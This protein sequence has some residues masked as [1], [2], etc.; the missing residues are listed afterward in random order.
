MKASP[1][2]LVI[3]CMPLLAAIAFCCGCRSLEQQVLFHPAPLAEGTRAAMFAAEDVGFESGDGTR[4]HGWYFR[5]PEPRAV[6]L[7]CHGNGGNLTNWAK[8]VRQLREELG[9][10]VLIFDYRGYG[11][12]EGKPSIAGI[13]D[14]ARAARA[15]LAAREGIGE[16][17]IVLM[18]HSLGGAVAVDLAA[19]DGAKALVVRGSFTSLPDIAGDH[20][21][22]LPASW[23]LSDELDSRAKLAGYSGPTLIAHG[24][25]DSLIPFH[26]GEEL[27]Q[28]AAGPKKF[29]P[30]AGAGHNDPPDDEL[31]RELAI[32]FAYLDQQRRLVS[33]PP[34]PLAPVR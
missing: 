13:L 11:R 2:M 14:D 34:T 18:G 28:A 16:R 15:W 32:L 5:H 33:L 29:V 1:A 30:L 19:R 20:A 12:S 17:E 7:F 25:A 26:H 4:L 9:A 21:S 23:L 3:H 6:V 8:E 22:W 10:S 27:F 31:T 24:D